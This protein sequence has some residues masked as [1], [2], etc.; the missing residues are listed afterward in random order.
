MPKVVDH[1]ARRAALVEAAFP[2]FA[3]Q[4]YH[5]LS[6]RSL[7]QGLGVSTG[8]LYH[9][10]GDKPAIFE[11]MV[12]RMVADHV[13]RAGAMVGDLPPG[14]ALATFVSANVEPL[15]QAIRVALDFHRHQPD[16]R[17]LLAELAGAYRAGLQRDF[18]LGP[19]AAVVGLSL[20]V[21]ALVQHS[22]DPE[23]APVELQL[24]LA[25]GALGL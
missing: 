9:Y 21:G 16:G 1:D 3:E 19:E 23:G 7:A 4:G 20:I 14:E 8:T 22:L 15:S 17:P 24:R 13:A 5:A 10:F 12:R 11:A 18:G 6:V 25:L 2:L